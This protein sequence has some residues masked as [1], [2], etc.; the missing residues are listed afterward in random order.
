MTTQIPTETKLINRRLQGDGVSICNL[1]QVENLILSGV[2]PKFIVCEDPAPQIAQYNKLVGED[3]RILDSSTYTTNNLSHEW[4]FPEKYK[5][6]D[7]DSLI[8]TKLEA[9]CGN[10][11]DEYISKAVSRVELELKY[12]KETDSIDF[13]RCICFII[14][15]FKERTIFWGVG[16]GSSCAS[17]VLFLLE[18]H[19]VDPILYD[20]PISDFIKL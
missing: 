19:L 3:D 14:D 13:I 1:E 20:L 10:K 9:W 16:R 5:T 8:F 12:F 4:N 7:V 17:M 2:P 15:Y 6:L 11:S 18:L